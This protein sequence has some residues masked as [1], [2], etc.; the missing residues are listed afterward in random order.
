MG[1]RKIVRIKEKKEEKP[2]DLG[3]NVAD[4]VKSKDKIG[5]GKK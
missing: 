4:S 5:K 1:K 2:K 3:V